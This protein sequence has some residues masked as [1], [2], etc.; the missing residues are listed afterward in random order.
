[1]SYPMLEPQSNPTPSEITA[2]L[3]L[4]RAHKMILPT[5]FPILALATLSR[6][7]PTTQPTLTGGDHQPTSPQRSLQYHYLRHRHQP[8]HR[9]PQQPQCAVARPALLPDS[10]FTF[11]FIS[12]P[13][14]TARTSTGPSGKLVVVS[15]P[16]LDS[17]GQSTALGFFNPCAFDER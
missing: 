4:N 11:D 17:Q 14:I 6:I 7:L 15:S 2:C 10:A 13:P 16:A 1:M 12:P 8:L 5:L 9:A 3:G